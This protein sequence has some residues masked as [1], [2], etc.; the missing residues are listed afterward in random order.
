M[1]NNNMEII[2]FNDLNKK[3]YKGNKQVISMIDDAAQ[4]FAKLEIGY[5]YWNSYEREKV[6][7]HFIPFAIN[8]L[9]T[10]GKAINT[11]YLFMTNTKEVFEDDLLTNN[12]VLNN[13]HAVSCINKIQ[14]YFTMGMEWCREAYDLNN[15]LKNCISEFETYNEHERELFFK[16]H[17]TLFTNIKEIM[18]KNIETGDAVVNI[19]TQC[20]QG[21][22]N[23]YSNINKHATHQE[24]KAWQIIYQHG[25]SVNKMYTSESNKIVR[26]HDYNQWTN[27]MLLTMKKSRL[28][29]LQEMNV[30][31][32]KPMKIEIEFTLVH[33]SDTDN[34]IKSFLDI[35]V[36]YYK[37]R[38]DNNF[39]TINVSRNPEWA[40][41]YSDGK[42]KFRIENI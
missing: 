2:D 37:M 38:D 10:I 1:I 8:L 33:G 13:K 14:N 6:M 31:P 15:K 9:N 11:N 36:K 23:Y 3:L 30:N 39:V 4:H 16:H 40:R 17:N 18:N 24:I 32:N 25:F 22:Q 29:S 12:V 20:V 42:I 41:S 5:E 34:C 21:I 26:S 27:K 28:K 7:S 35:L 19:Y